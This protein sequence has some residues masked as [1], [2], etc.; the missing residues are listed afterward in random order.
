MKNHMLLTM[1]M[2]GLFG[3]SAWAAAGGI[4]THAVSAIVMKIAPYCSVAVGEAQVHVTDRLA[5][6][7]DANVT[8]VVTANFAAIVTPTI[9]T[10]TGYTV[11]EKPN[12]VWTPTIGA[13]DHKDIAAGVES[14]TPVNVAI[15]DVA[16][17]D[18]VISSWTKVATLTVTITARD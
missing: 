8:C 13:A 1:L 9:I 6:A 10:F 15:S 3:G 14:T 5:G 2:V 16:L 4:G 12:W 17:T 11:T 7:A 18:T